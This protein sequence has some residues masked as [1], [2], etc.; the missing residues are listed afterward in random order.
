MLQSILKEL[1][2]AVFLWTLQPHGQHIN[3]T[4]LHAALK[5]DC[6]VM[7]PKHFEGTVC[8]G[9]PWLQ[10]HREPTLESYTSYCLISLA[11]IS[12]KLE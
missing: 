11:S 4:H 10:P 2:A 1:F 8:C 9:F 5:D 12:F 6:R 7:L 3:L